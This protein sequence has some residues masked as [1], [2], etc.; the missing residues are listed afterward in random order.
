[1]HSA[2]KLFAPAFN[3]AWPRQVE[4]AD[5]ADPQLTAAYRLALLPARLG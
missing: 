1:M 2:S 5:D 3:L 4:K